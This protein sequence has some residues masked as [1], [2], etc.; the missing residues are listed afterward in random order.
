[1]QARQLWCTALVASQHVGSSQT[2]GQTHVPCIGRQILIHQTTRE[3]LQIVIQ[4]ET[5]CIITITTC[6][7]IIISAF[8]W[9]KIIHSIFLYLVIIYHALS[10]VFISKYVMCITVGSS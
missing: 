9:L 2:R 1:M 3:V 8:F 6:I 4:K 7:T 10:R 5:T